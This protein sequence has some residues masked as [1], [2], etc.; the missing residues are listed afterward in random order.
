MN[1]DLIIPSLSLPSSITPFTP[2]WDGAERVKLFIKRDDAIHPII[3]GNKWRKLKY[4]LLALPDCTKGIVSFGGGHSNHLHALGFIC[5]S[6][7]IEFHAIIRGNYHLN[8]T[9]MIND[10]I[11][12]GTKIHYVTKHTYSHRN[13]PEYL[14]SLQ[15]EFP[16]MAIIPEGG[17]QDDAIRGVQEMVDEIEVPFDSILAPVASG[18]TLAGIISALQ[19]SQKAHGIGVL[20]GQEYLVSLVNQFLPS[21]PPDYVLHH[22]YHCGG[23]AK[24]PDYLAQFCDEFNQTMP[25]QIEGVYSGK[26]F[27]ALKSLL[28]MHFFPEGHNIV[29]VHTGGLQGNRRI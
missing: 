17:S 20:K 29:I 6:L 5:H 23:Y 28:N 8:P 19:P 4:A 22:S 7:N 11:H 13:S 16:N 24:I 15:T 26:V 12:Y 14:Q 3:S 27:W 1:I 9:P 18:A 10:L 25:C 21:E 2:N